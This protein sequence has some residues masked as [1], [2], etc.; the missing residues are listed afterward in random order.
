MTCITDLRGFN[1]MHI[2]IKLKAVNLIECM[3]A[4]T[5]Q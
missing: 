5:K 4:H 3:W 2:L 1:Y